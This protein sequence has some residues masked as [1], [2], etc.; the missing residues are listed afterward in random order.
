MTRTVGLGVADT[1]KQAVEDYGRVGVLVDDVVDAAGRLAIELYATPELPRWWLVRRTMID[2]IPLIEE[3]AGLPLV[4]ALVVIDQYLPVAAGGPPQRWWGAPGEPC[5]RLTRAIEGLPP[6]ERGGPPVCF[7]SAYPTLDAGEREVAPRG[8][9]LS[10]SDAP[11]LRELYRRTAGGNQDSRRAPLERFG[12][13]HGPWPAVLREVAE[14]LSDRRHHDVWLLTGAGMSRRRDAEGGGSAGASAGMPGNAALLR[15]AFRRAL[16]SDDALP[17]QLPLD[18]QRALGAEQVAGLQRLFDGATDAPTFNALWR[19]LPADAGIVGQFRSQIELGLRAAVT[20]EDRGTTHQHLLAAQ[21]PFRWVITT[22]FDAQHERAAVVAGSRQSSVTAALETLSR[23]L[24]HPGTAVPTHGNAISPR[25]VRL[26]GSVASG[27]PLAVDEAEF[28][29]R[30]SAWAGRLRTPV[31]RRASLLIVGHSLDDPA[32][33]A[34]LAKFRFS[35]VWYV[36]PEPMTSLPG[37]HP[38]H[39]EWRRLQNRAQWV[40]CRAL[41]FFH[42]LHREWLESGSLR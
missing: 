22:N 9:W 29:T 25:L 7:I 10:R 36:G 31:G 24:A 2:A 30:L 34:W 17:Q 6:Q 15:T 14:D 37:S 8:G 16:R 33:R 20:A 41:D 40:Q 1:V 19:G 5:Q 32:L 39:S 21:L 28:E 23:G 35:R 42:D 11:V 38:G 27:E 4:P 3:L 18:L 26:Y 12:P 13:L